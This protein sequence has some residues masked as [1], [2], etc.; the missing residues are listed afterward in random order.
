MSSVHD[1]PVHPLP[2][3][4]AQGIKAL[5]SPTLAP[6]CPPTALSSLVLKHPSHNLAQ[7]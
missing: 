4:Q 1:V 7:A 6:D 3:H 5:L 2:D